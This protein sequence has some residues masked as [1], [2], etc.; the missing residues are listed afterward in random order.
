MREFMAQHIN[1]FVA[2]GA[3][4]DLFAQLQTAVT[5]V[6]HKAAEHGTGVG[7]ARQGTRTRAEGRDDLQA[8]VDAIYN[9]ARTMGVESQF[10]RPALNNDSALLQAADVYA[11]N[12][13]PLKA[14]FIAHEL[15]PDFLEDLAADKAAFQAAIADQANAVGDHISARKDLD[16]ALDGGVDIVRKLTGII[17]VKYANSGGKLAKWT[18]ASHIERAPRRAKPASGPP[19]AGGPPAG[20]TPPP[21]P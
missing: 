13:L 16:D 8:G 1:D 4:R 15:P 19:P 18:A 21:T 17:K 9:A 14:Q 2:A 3:A 20:G 11:T 5:D 10:P 6:E 7:Q 12:A